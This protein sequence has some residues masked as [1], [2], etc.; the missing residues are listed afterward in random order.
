[1]LLEKKNGQCRLN[2]SVVSRRTL[3]QIGRKYFTAESW[4]RLL[5][6]LD[7]FGRVHVA[8]VFARVNQKKGRLK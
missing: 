5:R 3:E 8:M 4:E 7:R 2:G 6:D 1:M